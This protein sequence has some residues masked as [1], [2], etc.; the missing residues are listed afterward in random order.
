[1]QKKRLGLQGNQIFNQRFGGGGGGGVKAFWR[2][3]RSSEK[4]LAKPLIKK[5]QHICHSV[6]LL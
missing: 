5:R 6:R 3:V 2:I 1:M 4:N